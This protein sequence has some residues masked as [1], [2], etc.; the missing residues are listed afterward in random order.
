MSSFQNV[1]QFNA[2]VSSLCFQDRQYIDYYLQYIGQPSGSNIP[3]EIEAKASHA[4]DNDVGL[5]LLNLATVGIALMRNETQRPEAQ[6]WSR[7]P[8]SS[9]NR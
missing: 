6:D 8:E 5:R 2:Y 4:L 7:R 1:Q 3:R 9:S